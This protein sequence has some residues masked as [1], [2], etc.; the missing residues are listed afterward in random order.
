MNDLPD[1]ELLSA[2]LDGEAT[3]AERRQ[4]EQLLAASPAARETLEQLR[5]LSNTLHSL[6]Q[7]K[8]GADLGPRVLRLA[9]RR[10]LTGE[11]RDS[12]HVED[13]PVPLGPSLLGRFTRPRILIWLTITAII[14][15]II[16]VNEERQ[17]KQ[18]AR[19]PQE[20]ASA[21]ATSGEPSEPSRITAYPSNTKAAKPTPV[22]EPSES[23]RSLAQSL[24]VECQEGKLPPPK[25]SADRFAPAEPAAGAKRGGH[26]EPSGAS[27]V[28]RQPA[29]MVMVVHCDVSPQAAKR[30]TFEKLLARNG[31]VWQHYGPAE[32]GQ[33]SS[34]LEVVYVE[35]AAGQVQA[36]LKGLAGQRKAF[37]SFR[38]QSGTPYHR[39]LTN[40]RSETPMQ[41]V[42]FVL[43]MR[44]GTATAASA[45]ASSAAAATS[46]KVADPSAT[47][48]PK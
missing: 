18:A 27:L 22:G 10:M 40:Q 25:H 45:A 41:R 14:A 29:E 34:P 6:P 1:N 32:A 19:A 36:I 11:Q 2:Y 30:R 13:A 48:P 39:A 3:S 46:T 38:V 16:R 31:V 24:R 44:D 21:P 12:A 9:E 37:P 35:A 15:V 26:D 5:A 23:A 42:I 28:R 20:A 7:E 17:G 8:I 47:H 4:V 43:R 33:S